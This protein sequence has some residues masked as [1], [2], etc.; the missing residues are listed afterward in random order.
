MPL[1]R[2]ATGLRAY[3]HVNRYRQILTTL[4][5]YGFGDL[6][7][8]LRITQYIELGLQLIGSNKRE[9]IES[10]TTAQRTRLILEELGPTFIKL[11]QILSTRPD[12]LPHDFVEELRRLQQHVAPFEFDQVEQIV[13][14]ELG[15]PLS[16]LFARFDREPIAAASIAQV[17]RAALHD[18]TE[19]VVKVQRPNIRRVVEVDLEILYDLATLVE[20]HFEHWRV[21]RPSQI[22]EEFARL[23]EQELD[24]SLEARHVERFA[25]QFRTDRTIAVPRVFRSRCS[26]RVLTLEYMDVTPVTDPGSLRAAGFDPALI[27]QRGTELTLKQIFVHGFFHGDPHPGNIFTLPGN[28]ICLLDFG[29]MGR[30]NRASREQFADLVYAIARNDSAAA[31]SALLR[32]TEHDDDVEVDTRQLESDVTR[33]VDVHVVS[34]L[35]QVHFGRLISGL[36]DLLA[37]HRLRIPA[38]LVMMLKAAATVE[39]LA[40]SLDPNLD[41]VAAARPYVRR[42]QFDRIRPRRL[43]RETLDAARDLIQFARDIPGGLR[44]VLRLAKRGGLKLGFEHRGLDRLIDSNERIANRVSF[45]IVV[46]ALI[47]GSSLIVQSRLP[48]TWNGI[49][50]IGLLGYIAAGI[51]G[52]V[53]LIAII[54]H[55]RL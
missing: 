8:R 15:R 43:I 3:R 5:R 27:A 31:S 7:D 35:S 4:I 53:L 41:M 14:D 12:I 42:I 23:I 30:L 49:P 10:L 47:V 13:T 28:V 45:S 6:V 39:R 17:H 52:F 11:G 40:A 48:P 37:E 25:E 32:L 33:L 50:V 54:R 16:E 44:D 51:M 36:F 20:R 2:T 9:H 22:A 55:G 24:F 46:A 38:D 19:V 26:P 29:L 18:G 21:Q 1:S 34:Q